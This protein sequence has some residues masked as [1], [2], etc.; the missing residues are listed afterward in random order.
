MGVAVGVGG[1]RGGAADVGEGE[2]AVEAATTDLQRP[3]REQPRDE[4]AARLA[5]GFERGAARRRVRHRDLQRPST[6]CLGLQG[7]LQLSHVLGLFDAA[8]VDVQN[9]A[10]QLQRLLGAVVDR[11]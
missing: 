7:S 4:L 3:V 10:K 9:R 5:K 6:V 1:G 11:L 8:K 2:E